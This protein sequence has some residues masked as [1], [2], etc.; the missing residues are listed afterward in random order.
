MTDGASP[1]SGPSKPLKR[2]NKARDA[3]RILLVMYHEAGYAIV[4]SLLPGVDPV[5][6]ISIV[7]R[8]S[9]ALG[10]TLQL[11]VEE[12]YLVTRQALLNQ[13]AVLLGGR[14]AEETVF[15]E[16]STGAQNDLQ[17]ATD[18]ARAMVAE[19]GMSEALG[20]VAFK[21]RARQ[22]FLEAP[23]LEPEPFVEE[24]AHLIDN[25]IKQLIVDAHTRASDILRERRS[26]L[27]ALA[28]RL[29]EQEVV[30]GTEVRD[31]IELTSS[32]APQA[33]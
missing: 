21:G 33:A 1:P 19:Y 4:A 17:R 2:G 22:R 7:Q 18:L 32:S 29:M 16:I 3:T 5:H 8:G 26:V 11:P 23:G 30:E 31:L 25:E 9:A 15:Q 27:I 6:K 20:P 12:H 24:T 14:S 28:R 10:H 13:L